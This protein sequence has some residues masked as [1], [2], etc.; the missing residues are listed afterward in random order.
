MP[1]PE[2]VP[3]FVLCG[4]LGTRLGEAGARMPKPLVEI[5]DRPL[6]AHLIECYSRFGYRRFILC[7]GHRAE[8]LA[9]YF[10]LLPG[11]VDDFTVDLASGTV[12]HHPTRPALEAAITVAHTGA[13]AGT[14]A[15]IARACAR[16][17]GEAEHFA[18]TYGDGLTDADLGAELAFHL[19]HGAI[20]TVLAVNPPSQFGHLEIDGDRVVRFAEKPPGARGWI[21]GGFFLFH[22][23]FL[24]YLREEADCVLERD[25]LERLAADGELR[26]FRH[27]GFWSCVDTPR[28]RARLHALC[29][30][31]APPWRW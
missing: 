14:G 11:L 16:Y 8:V 19:R 22:R 27:G 21:N 9:A 24:R 3:V 6:L 17:L 29:E 25:P 20:G 12:T 15:R 5:G 10:L 4:G 2:E 26:V 1:S 13:R 30:S 31:G 7:A 18:V 23:R 28:D